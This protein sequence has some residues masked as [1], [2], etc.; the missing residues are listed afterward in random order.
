M[1]R[2]HS[3]SIPVQLLQLIGFT[4]AA[5]GLSAFLDY[6]PRA[7]LTL[8]HLLQGIAAAPLLVAIVGIAHAGLLALGRF[9]HAQTLELERQLLQRTPRTARIAAGITAA[10][11]EELLLR[12]FLF[13]YLA[14]Y[15]LTTA[16]LVNAATT[17]L[18]HFRGKRR[19]TWTAVRVAEGS[20]AALIYYSQHS[21]LGLMV[22]RGISYAILNAIILSPYAMPLIAASAKSWRQPHALFRKTIEGSNKRRYAP[23]SV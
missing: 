5:C 9:A 12:I 11:G 19:L 2:W 17:F 10:C 22:A 4:L 15:S 7:P 14:L 18:L 6:R 3:R 8:G 13:G 20:L 21:F 1:S 23:R 16:L